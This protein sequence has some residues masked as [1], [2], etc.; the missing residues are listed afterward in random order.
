MLIQLKWLDY[1]PS[2]VK[3][4]C[5]CGSKCEKCACGLGIGASL[6][7]IQYTV[8]TT[9]IEIKVNNVSNRCRS[10]QIVGI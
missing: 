10:L 2:I 7:E 1:L 3:D 4:A 5:G 6:G 8:F 9:N